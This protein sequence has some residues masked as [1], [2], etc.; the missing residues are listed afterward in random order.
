MTACDR[1]RAT[2]PDGT[3]R[4]QARLRLTGELGALPPPGDPAAGPGELMAALAAAEKL[5]EAE[6]MEAV[7]EEFVFT[8]CPGCRADLRGDPAGA[9]SAPAPRGGVPQ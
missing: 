8:L 3:L 4:F 6:L 9:R 5:S 7:V 2:L 1:C